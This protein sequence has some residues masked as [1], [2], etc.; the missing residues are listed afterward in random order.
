MKVV[1]DM[2]WI[3]EDIRELY[4]FLA[5]E[6]YTESEKYRAKGAL[7]ALERLKSRILES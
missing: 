1:I 5:C 6:K 2:N 3:N 4:R 7:I